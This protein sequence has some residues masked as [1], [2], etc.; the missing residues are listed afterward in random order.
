M[1]LMCFAVCHLIDEKGAPFQYTSYNC[2]T[3]SEF[4][5]GRQR[6]NVTRYFVCIKIRAGLLL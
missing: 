3:T 6:L 4:V 2:D 5:E 1:C